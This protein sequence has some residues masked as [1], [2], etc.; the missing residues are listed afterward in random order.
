MGQSIDI[1]E[2]AF[3]IG[4]LL[5]VILSISLFVSFIR[6][7]TS[8]SRLVIGILLIQTL[9]GTTRDTEADTENRGG[10]LGQI[11]VDGREGEHFRLLGNLPVI[12]TVIEFGAQAE[13][14]FPIAPEAIGEHGI[15]LN[16]RGRDNL[17]SRGRGLF[18]NGDGVLI[19]APGHLDILSKDTGRSDERGRSN[20]NK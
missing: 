16:N 20:Q 13:I 7:E 11:S 18:H 12:L 10:P 6:L 1:Q 17:T 8:I 2:T 3:L 19:L 4:Q 9:E 14:Q 15:L 5:V